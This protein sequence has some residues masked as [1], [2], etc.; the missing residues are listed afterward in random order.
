MPTFRFLDE[1][2]KCGHPDSHRHNVVLT[3][4]VVNEIVEYGLKGHSHAI[5]VHF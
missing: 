3:C 2:L 5:L 4:E 1:I